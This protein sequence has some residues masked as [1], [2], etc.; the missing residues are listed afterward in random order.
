MRMEEEV[1]PGTIRLN[2]HKTPQK[3]YQNNVGWT[4][5]KIPALTI[6]KG[7]SKTTSPNKNQTPE[8]RFRPCLP[9]SRYREG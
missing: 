7:I 6:A 1:I 5:G 3:K 4:W 9:A 8:E 2:P